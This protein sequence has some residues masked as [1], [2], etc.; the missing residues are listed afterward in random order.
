MCVNSHATG[1]Q[2]L[3]LALAMVQNLQQYLPAKALVSGVASSKAS[4]EQELG[5]GGEA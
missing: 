4:Q 5:Q 3:E 2:A 1:S